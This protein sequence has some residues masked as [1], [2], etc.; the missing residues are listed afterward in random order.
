MLGY[1]KQGNGKA[2]KRKKAEIYTK[3]EFI[4]KGSFLKFFKYFY[5][6]F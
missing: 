6:S 2:S 3:M 5:N 1:W 4:K